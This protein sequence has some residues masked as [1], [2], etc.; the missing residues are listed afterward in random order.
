MT[1]LAPQV[2]RAESGDERVRLD[3]AELR[4]GRRVHAKLVIARHPGSRRLVA[5]LVDDRPD[6]TART[7]VTAMTATTAPLSCDNGRDLASRVDASAA[8]REAANT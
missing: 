7:V 5:R 4:Q 6:E 8:E 1:S 3:F 2:R